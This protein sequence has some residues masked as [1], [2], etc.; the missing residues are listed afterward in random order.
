MVIMKLLLQEECKHYG[1]QWVKIG[2]SILAKWIN[3]FLQ[4]NHN[5]DA[6]SMKLISTTYH[7]CGY[8]GNYAKY[9]YIN[10][11]LPDPLHCQLTV[12]L[13]LRYLIV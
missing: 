4:G 6:L 13:M 3:R 2:S 10:K 12:I 5:N 7:L 11:T 8:H 9:F 1:Y